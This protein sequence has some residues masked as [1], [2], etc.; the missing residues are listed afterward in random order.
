MAVQ[1]TEKGRKKK[2][3]FAQLSYG[4]KSFGVMWTKTQKLIIKTYKHTVK[5]ANDH[6]GYVSRTTNKI[7]SKN[8]TPLR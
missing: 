4:K 7:Y 6:R 5:C 1:I 3:V 2:K 8:K